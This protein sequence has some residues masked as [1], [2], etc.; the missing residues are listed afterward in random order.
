MSSLVALAGCASQLKLGGSLDRRFPLA[1]HVTKDQD[2]SPVALPCRPDPTKKDPAH[3]ACAPET[4]VSP[5]AWDAIDNAMA[6]PI[7]E[8]L[9]VPATTEAI[10]A[11]ALDEVATS[12]WFTPRLG[13][14]DV[15]LEEITRGACEPAQILDGATAAEGEWVI[16]AGKSNGS[17]PGFRVNIPGRGKYMFKSDDA[18]GERPTASSVIGAAIYHAAGFNT[19][20]EQ[21]VYFNPRVLKLTPGLVTQDNS[22]LPRP[23]DAAA[24][25]KV[26]ERAT[27]RGAFIRM[28]ASA[29]LPGRLIGPFRYEGTRNDDP[30]DVVPHEDRRELRGG[31][32]LAAWTEHH[33]AREQNSMDSWISD[34]GKKSPDASPGFVRHYYLDTSDC[35]GSEW[36]WEAVSKRLGYSYLLDVPD[37]SADFL[38]LGIVTRPWDTA[39]RVPGK[40]QFGFYDVDSFVPEEWKNEYQNPAFSRMT[41]RDAAWMARILARITPPMVEAFVRSGKFTKAEDSAYLTGVMQGRLDKIMKRYLTRLSPLGE[42]KQEGDTICAADLSRARGMF[43][44]SSYRYTASLSGGPSIKASLSI[45]DDGKVCV[46]VPH[47]PGLPDSLRDDAKER[48]TVLSVDNGLSRTPLDVHLYDLGERGFYLAGIERRAPDQ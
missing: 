25:A 10:N 47:K 30:N 6:R 8:T 23:F 32:M 31:R 1:P 11:T 34:A 40:E 24:L 45:H 15:P 7:T 19:S 21:I 18:Q 29:W 16:D 22:G 33:D 2:L 44:P 9:K 42:V 36:E 14:R 39:R 38:T 28:Q 4:Y 12:A 26:F 13:A 3:V 20:C 35:F 48:Y 27:K 41:E 46:K 5:L 37:I 17:S 43:A